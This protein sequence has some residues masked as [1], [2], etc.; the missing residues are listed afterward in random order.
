MKSV[1]VMSVVGA[2]LCDGLGLENENP[3]SRLLWHYVSPRMVAV[4]PTVG[5]VAAVWDTW[6]E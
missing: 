3:P 1:G 4:R 5:A 6:D 2:V